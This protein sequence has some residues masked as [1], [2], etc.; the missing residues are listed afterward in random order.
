MLLVLLAALA[1]LW[2]SL[3]VENDFSESEGAHLGVQSG[4]TVEEVDE[5]ALL[6]GFGE[7]R[8]GRSVDFL[9]ATRGNAGKQVMNAE[10]EAVEARLREMQRRDDEGLVVETM[11]GGHQ[12]IHL[13]GRFQHVTRLVRAEDGRM[14]PVCGGYFQDGERESVN[15]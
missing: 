11:P 4:D 6:S 2:L 13:Q 7:A 8:G 14:V 3:S 12:S 10:R 5:V 1:G 9:R 15:E